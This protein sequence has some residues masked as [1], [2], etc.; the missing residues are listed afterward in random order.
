M[1]LGA[2][3]FAEQ[4]DRIYLDPRPSIAIEDGARR[5]LT[6]TAGQSGTAVVWNPWIA[7]AHAL[8]DLADDE[9]ECFVCVET[10]N[11]ER[12]SVVLPAGQEHVMRVV[13]SVE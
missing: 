6:L 3:A 5:R 9:W 7:K 12:R 11:V 2:I 8:Q 10:C 13:I 4:T 1:Q